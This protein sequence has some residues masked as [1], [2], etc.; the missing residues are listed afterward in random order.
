MKWL[1]ILDFIFMSIAYGSAFA[2][3]EQGLKY[4]SAG[5]IQAMRMW[6]GLATCI[7]IMI[8]R[9]IVSKN[10]PALVKTHFTSGVWPIIHLIIGGLLNLGVPHCLIAVAQAWVPTVTVQVLMPI[11]T[12]A[13]AIAGHFLLD[14][15]KFDW[16][17]GL[18]LLLA[19]I[20]VILCSVPQFVGATIS[21]NVGKVALGFF[22]IFISMIMFGI[23]PVYFKWKVPNVDLTVSS[24]VQ[25]LFSGIFCFIW[26]LIF[27]GPNN[28]HR[29]ASDAPPIAWMWPAI[30]GSIASGLAVHGLMYLVEQIGAFC[31]NFL[32]FGQTITGMIIGIAAL[33]EWDGY[34]WWEIL[35]SVIGIIVLFS[36]MGVGFYKNAAIKKDEVVEE[37]LKRVSSDSGETELSIEG[38]EEECEKVVPEL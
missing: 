1:A 36:S 17:K 16:K 22:L 6:F 2:G 9:L 21:G 14:D 23:A 20:G 18:S 25:T 11:A 32:P 24:S 7:L 37:E 15:E 31:T 19:L 10:Y 5:F 12:S 8:I 34:K 4:F 33:H 27:D 3:I 13:G 29:M 30:I 28:I 38:E 35:T 26:A